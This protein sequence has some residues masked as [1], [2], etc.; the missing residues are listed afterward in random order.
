MRSQEKLFT[1]SVLIEAAA[2]LPMVSLPA[3]AIWLLLG[4]R[5]PSPDMVLRAADNW[6]GKALVRLHLHVPLV[7][8]YFDRCP[9]VRG[10]PVP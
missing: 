7:P 2:G 8:Q 10:V 5:E 3:L 4:V 1:A 9:T 6:N